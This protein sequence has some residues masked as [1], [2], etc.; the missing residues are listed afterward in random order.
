MN[1]WTPY[2]NF[3][4]IPFNR[5]FGLK[6]LIDNKVAI[7]GIHANDFKG[8]KTVDFS[9]LTNSV[10]LPV[11][12]NTVLQLLDHLYSAIDVI[13]GANI[14]AYKPKAKDIKLYKVNGFDAAGIKDP[15]NKIFD[16]LKFI[17]NGAHESYI[18]NDYV[19]MDDVSD[20]VNA[21]KTYS[22][23]EGMLHIGTDSQ[24]YAIKTFFSPKNN[25]MGLSIRKNVRDETGEVVQV[26]GSLDEVYS[27][28]RELY[29]DFNFKD[30]LMHDCKG[31]ILSLLA[32]NT[33]NAALIRKG[34]KRSTSAE[35]NAN[36]LRSTLNK[37]LAKAKCESNP[38]AVLATKS[39]V[40]KG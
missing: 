27:I 3:E 38:F 13:E 15:N 23:K 25:Y 1:A 14:T 26:V 29:I 37:D 19:V 4:V 31:D 40:R 34:A 12:A 17:V 33:A 16:T 24:W 8:R 21:K 36:S 9:F 20:F 7:I 5:G 18:F 39:K 28:F 35:T 6:T 2:N 11:D 30:V 10:M 22:Q 32:N